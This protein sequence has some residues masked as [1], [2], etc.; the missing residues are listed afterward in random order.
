MSKPP[1]VN[2]SDHAVL[3]YLERVLN[4]PIEQLRAQIKAECEG[5]VVAGA[6]SLKKD[7]FQYHFDGYSVKTV[8]TASAFPSLTARE[9]CADPNRRQKRP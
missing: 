4:M 5:A 3:R 9:F 1:E 7:G 8:T 2:V 6:R